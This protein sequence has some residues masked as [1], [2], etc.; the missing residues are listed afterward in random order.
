M[1]TLFTFVPRLFVNALDMNPH[2]ASM[3]KLLATD[4]TGVL[5]PLVDVL[6][7]PH[8]GRVAAQ[9]RLALVAWVRL[10]HVGAQHVVP[11]IRFPL[12]RKVTAGLWALV[13]D[14]FVN[15]P[16]VFKEVHP[17]GVHLAT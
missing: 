6:N 11:P 10:P 3:R 13:R 8:S 1:L 7:V 17:A 16:Y 9:H 14:L 4:G 12:E 5:D 2:S 15:V